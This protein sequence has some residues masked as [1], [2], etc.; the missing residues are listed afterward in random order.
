[1]P[2]NPTEQP[3][4]PQGWKPSRRE[5]LGIGGAAVIGGG[6]FAGIRRWRRNENGQRSEV[7]ICKASRYDANLV[8][9]IL[10]G[11]RELGID[12]A[13]VRGK[14]ILLKPNLV[15]TDLGQPHI[16]TSPAVVA[17]AI[18]SF[19]RLDAADVVVAEGQ[20]HRR[21]SWL[22]LDES[23]MG[24]AI[25]EVAA[26]FVD[27]NHDEFAAVDNA[28]TWTSLEKLHLP[29]TLLQADWVVS[30]P[31][32]KTHHWAGVTCAMK[33]LF[34]VMPG[35]VYGW[36]KNVLHHQGINKSILDINAT[37]KPSLAIVDGIIGME[38]DGPIMGTPKAANCLILGR[39]AASVDATATRI[40][41]LN[42]YAVG[43]LIGASGRL[44]AIH[45]SNISQRGEPI[46]AMK[47][48]FGVLDA[49][50]LRSIVV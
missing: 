45:E 8:A 49:P 25:E 41:G 38:G 46:D 37:V 13:A 24:R 30:M 22:V 36:P 20:G 47:T 44:G 17:A 21:D 14:R 7:A 43:Y 19:R 28:G 6:V 33:N 2:E 3:E 5:L 32:L 9:T 40:M 39:N 23:G 12:R 31:K 11:L 42:P 10:D 35:I 50:H 1:M 16:N 15:E 26:T 27:L 18:E 4:Q 48:R 34:G 29:K